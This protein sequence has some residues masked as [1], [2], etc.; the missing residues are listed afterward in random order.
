MK[1][2]DTGHKTVSTMDRKAHAPDVVSRQDTEPE[3]T[4]RGPETSSS[5]LEGVSRV[6]YI[7]QLPHGFYEEQLKGFFDQF[8]LVTR[9]RVSR[10]NKTG[11]AKHY[12]FVEFQS[13][14]VAVIAA[15]AMDNYMMFKQKLRVNIVKAADLHPQLFKGANKKFRAIPRQK[16]SRDQHNRERTAEEDERRVKKAV[17]KDK[18]RQQRIKAAGIDYEYEPLQALM[19]ATPTHTKFK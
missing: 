6:I 16:L 12:A 4:G 13:P 9:L 10:N 3:N 18:Q 8:G 19:P 11:K 1:L 2:T 14:E 5:D 17:A 15:E 7:G